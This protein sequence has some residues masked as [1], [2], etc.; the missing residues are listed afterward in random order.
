MILWNQHFILLEEKIILKVHLNSQ[1]S[2]LFPGN[3]NK[4][5]KIDIHSFS[6][7]KISFTL[8]QYFFELH[9]VYYLKN[10]LLS[11]IRLKFITLFEYKYRSRIQDTV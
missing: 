6:G 1:V 4:I 3:W 8:Y 5:N 9:F 11:Y 2:E 10:N 7:T